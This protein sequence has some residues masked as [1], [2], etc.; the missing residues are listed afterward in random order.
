MLLFI[1]A[2]SVLEYKL[3]FSTRA[4]W[5]VFCGKFDARPQAV[6]VTRCDVNFMLPPVTILR[7]EVPHTPR[8]FLQVIGVLRSLTNTGFD[9][10][11]R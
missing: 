5:V 8:L 1:F 3:F 10:L 11:E 2:I 9:V 7:S 6:R 4:F